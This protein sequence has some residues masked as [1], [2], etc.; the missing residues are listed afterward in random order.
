[1]CGW[2]L[3]HD[4]TSRVIAGRPPD[5]QESK[6]SPAFN[7]NVTASG[8]PCTGELLPKSSSTGASLTQPS[9]QPSKFEN[10]QWLLDSRVDKHTCSMYGLQP[11]VFLADYLSGGLKCHSL[12]PA[13]KKVEPET[14]FS[15]EG[16]PLVLTGE[17]FIC[18]LNPGSNIWQYAECRST[19]SQG[20]FLVR[21]TR[22]APPCRRIMQI[23]GPIQYLNR[24]PCGH[25]CII[26]DGSP[27]LSWC[28]LSS[29]SCPPS[30]T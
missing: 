7:I 11:S 4:A 5:P 6:S 9:G 15:P 16:L 21:G 23:L 30:H 26:G 22:R 20:P 14:E 3:W 12:P 24:R 2:A 27:P 25:A 19:P 17:L 10:T 28:T 1:M 13:D 8:Y 29:D 18:E